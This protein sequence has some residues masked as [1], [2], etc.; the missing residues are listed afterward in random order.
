MKTTILKGYKSFELKFTL[1]RKVLTCNGFH[2]VIFQFEPSFPGDTASLTWCDRLEFLRSVNKKPDK[3]KP[4]PVRVKFFKDRAKPDRTAA[5]PLAP[6]VPYASRLNLFENKRIKNLL[7]DVKVK[8]QGQYEW[9]QTTNSSQI[10]QV[11][12]DSDSTDID[13]SEESDNVVVDDSEKEDDSQIEASLQQKIADKSRM[14]SIKGL[15]PSTPMLKRSESVVERRYNMP[16]LVVRGGGWKMERA[17]TTL[18][19]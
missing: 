2:F 6:L 1:T 11:L 18:L 9:L 17:Q 14:P 15:K 13:S 5:E 16:F 3:V 10:H 8:G 12:S 7:D 4:R 19:N